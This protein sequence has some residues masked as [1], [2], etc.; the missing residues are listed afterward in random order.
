MVDA[1][2]EVEEVVVV[3][4]SPEVEEVVVVDI[5]A[6]VEEVVAVDISLEAEEVVAVDASLEAEEMV[7]EASPV[8]VVAACRLRRYCLGLSMHERGPVVSPSAGKAKAVNTTELNK[9]QH[10]NT[11]QYM[12]VLFLRR[13]ECKA[14]NYITFNQPHLLT[15]PARRQ[16]TN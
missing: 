11:R 1:S 13:Q 2:S 10:N 3:D 14:Y 7:V 15:F 5:G 8:V 6:E 16:S 9:I 4:T 12:G